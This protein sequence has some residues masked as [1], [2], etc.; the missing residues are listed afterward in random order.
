MA[1]KSCALKFVMCGILESEHFIILVCSTCACYTMEIVCK[2]ISNNSPTY[3]D[4]YITFTLVSNGSLA[5]MHHYIVHYSGVHK[6]KMA[7]QLIYATKNGV[8]IWDI[9][10]P[11]PLFMQCP[12]CII[13]TCTYK[14]SKKIKKMRILCSHI[15]LVL[16]SCIL[17]NVPHPL[18]LY[19]IHG[20]ILKLLDFSVQ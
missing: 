14:T 3:I 15:I 1:S 17:K 18:Y 8:R 4:M 19:E 11:S 5:Y 7:H 20:S 10:F 6:T 16:P 12:Q 2:M 13:F 9:T